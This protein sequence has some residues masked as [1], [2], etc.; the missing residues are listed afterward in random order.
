M[1]TL[2]K[3]EGIGKKRRYANCGHG[4]SQTLETLLWG[5]IYGSQFTA[6]LNKE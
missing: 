5:E 3:K 2:L 4:D 1:Y 6:V